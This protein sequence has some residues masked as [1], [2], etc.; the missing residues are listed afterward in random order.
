[1]L[2]ISP[3]F[4]FEIKYWLHI[5]N[6]EVSSTLQHK[7]H[8]TLVTMGTPSMNLRPYETPLAELSKCSVAP[9]MAILVI[10]EHE[11]QKVW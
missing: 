2:H 9:T 10:V 7:V 8:H 11:Y 4:V 3:Y 6:A 1:M 5:N